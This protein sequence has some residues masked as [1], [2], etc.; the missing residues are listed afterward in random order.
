MSASSC[1]LGI[2]PASEFW[3][4]LTMT[5]TRIWMLLDSSLMEGSE[6]SGKLPIRDDGEWAHAGST[7]GDRFFCWRH[8][9][10]CPLAQWKPGAG[11][12][13]TTIAWTLSAPAIDAFD[14]ARG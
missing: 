12:P 13:L 10:R 2:T 4:A 6:G 5:M 14:P 1:S 3:V 7:R 11:A 9:M 8:A